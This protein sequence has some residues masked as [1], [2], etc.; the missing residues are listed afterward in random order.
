MEKSAEKT[1]STGML[2]KALKFAKEKHKGQKRDE[3]TEYFEHIKAVVKILIEE[4]I[5]DDTVL[6]VAAL[7]DVLEDTDT[8]YEEIEKE[9][10]TEVAGCVE[11]LTKKKNQ[12]FDVYAK[13]VFE[14]DEYPYARIIKLADRLHN[15]MT[16]L[17]T[18]RPEKI[19]RKVLETER[20]II[21]YEKC[22]SGNLMKKIKLEVEKIKSLENKIEF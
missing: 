4:G 17:Q 2:K 7:H 14:C 12:P 20:C 13:R 18:K 15:L 22:C 6:T 21:P 9:F 11:V 19:E 10:N 3:G 5:D 1:I 16:L 8:T